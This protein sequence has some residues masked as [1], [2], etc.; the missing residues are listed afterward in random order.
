M[1]IN[2]VSTHSRNES[3]MYIPVTW[4]K[5][6]NFFLVS[7][8]TYLVFGIVFVDLFVKWIYSFILNGWY[9]D[10]KISCLRLCLWTVFRRRGVYDRIR[11]WD[12][13]WQWR[14]DPLVKFTK[15]SLLSDSLPPSLRKER[16]DPFS[17][18]DECPG[19]LARTLKDFTGPVESHSWEDVFR[20]FH[21]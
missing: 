21:S 15:G 11:R 9:W 1:R 2:L 17:R 4:E 3:Y 14:R 10:T 16:G 12:L 8:F 6:K 7:F 18:R 5:G 19:S 13:N 20:Y